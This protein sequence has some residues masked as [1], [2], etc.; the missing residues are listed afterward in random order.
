MHENKAHCEGRGDWEGVIFA[1]AS[2]RRGTPNR[3]F[4]SPGGWVSGCR[5]CRRRGK[6]LV[7]VRLLFAEIKL[8]QALVLDGL[9]QLIL[10]QSLHHGV[11]ERLRCEIGGT[12]SQDG[13][14]VQDFG[15][16]IRSG[17]T[18]LC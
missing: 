17:I 14:V 12:E 13:I 8:A 5:C 10:E 1:T 6:D 7:D 15:R 3:P 16:E 9:E 4:G 2:G 18:A 11:L